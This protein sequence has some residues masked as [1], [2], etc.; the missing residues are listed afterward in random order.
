MII[1]HYTCALLCSFNTAQHASRQYEW[2]TITVSSNNY[3]TD[4]QSN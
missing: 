3:H 1:K 2:H 4:L